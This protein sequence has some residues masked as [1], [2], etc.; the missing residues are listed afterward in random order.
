MAT[1]TWRNVD[2]PR[3]DLRD[4]ALASNGVTESLDRVARLFAERE[5]RARQTATDNAL[6]QLYQQTTE[7]GLQNASAAIAAQNDPRVNLRALGEA[8]GAYRGQLLDQGVSRENLANLT[9]QTTFGSQIAEAAAAAETQDLARST[10]IVEQMRLDP[11]YGRVAVGAQRAISDAFGVGDARQFRD[12]EF[13]Y[14]KDR[15]GVADSQ[16]NQEFGLRLRAENRAAAAAAAAR[17]QAG[18]ARQRDLT[19][20]QFGQSLAATYPNINAVRR[21]SPEFR[22]MTSAEQKAVT[23]SFELNSAAYRENTPAGTDRVGAAAPYFQTKVDE[24]DVR[25]AQNRDLV[26]NTPARRILGN[27]E[28]TKAGNGGNLPDVPSAELRELVDATFPGWGRN[29]VSDR[30]AGLQQK[31]NLSNAEMS[32]IV[33]NVSPR[34]VI[35]RRVMGSDVAE[36]EELTEQYAS[37]AGNEGAVRL[38]AQERKLN[39]PV[40]EA[41]QGLQ[42][43]RDDFIRTGNAGIEEVPKSMLDGMNNA[44]QSANTILNAEIPRGSSSQRLPNRIDQAPREALRSNPEEAIR[45]LTLRE[46]LGILSPAERA[47]LAALRRNAAR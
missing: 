16:W 13:D 35:G 32:H 23:E 39:D 24:L 30:V 14:K 4:M 7:E 11:N 18:A 37:E 12:T 22:A 38:R 33:S 19:I 45:V 10:A 34:G 31:Y 1:L 42:A 44:V 47:T 20:E 36:L 29:S 25:E 2:A 40:R 15:D 5:A 21:N 3:I 41:R 27:I 6:G 46:N 8:A 9:A 28:Q 26:Y 43:S 17:Q